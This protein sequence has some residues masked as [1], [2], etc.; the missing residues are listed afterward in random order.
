[1]ILEKEM[2]YS[3]IIFEWEVWQF[4]VP[5]VEKVAPVHKETPN[6]PT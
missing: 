2:I 3:F 6:L 1:M 5:A 4:P